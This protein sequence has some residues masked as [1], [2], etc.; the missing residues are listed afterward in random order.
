MPPRGEDGVENWLLTAGRSP[1]EKMN[2]YCW[3]EQRSFVSQKPIVNDASTAAPLSRE[4]CLAQRRQRFGLCDLVPKEVCR[5]QARGLVAVPT[6]EPAGHDEGDPVA[7]QRLA[8]VAN[9]EGC[10]GGWRRRGPRPARHAPRRRQRQR[11]LLGRHVRCKC[12]T[13]NH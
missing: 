7:Q 11:R 3:A 1:W 2:S 4:G 5:R 12:A 8:L 9:L 6:G 13:G 10:D